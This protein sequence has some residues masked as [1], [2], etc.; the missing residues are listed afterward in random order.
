MTLRRLITALAITT[1]LTPACAEVL[2]DIRP[3]STLADIKKQYPAATFRKESAAW[4]QEWQ[5]FYSMTGHGFPGKLYLSF[6]DTRPYW[7]AEYE[8]VS[9]KQSDLQSPKDASYIV[10]VGEFANRTDDQALTID[11]VRWVPV[12]PIPIARVKGKYGNPSKC[13]FSDS[14]FTP[15][16]SWSSREISAVT[17]DDHKFV[18]LI[19]AGFTEAEIEQ[20]LAAKGLSTPGKDAKKKAS[21]AKK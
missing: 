12:D 2:H 19:T 10:M 6:R 7:R 9:S 20:A 8:R 5:A 16:C 21:A 15:F 1:A 11:W 14:D 17:S 4:V 3:L 13:G 18:I